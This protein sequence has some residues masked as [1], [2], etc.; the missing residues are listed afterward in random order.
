MPQ[1]E[2]DKPLSP[3]QR[4]AVFLALVEAQDGGMNVLR[5]R[6]AIAERFGLTDRQVRWIEQEGLECQWPPLE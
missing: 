3:E 5:S 1:R 2:A 6:K 4:K